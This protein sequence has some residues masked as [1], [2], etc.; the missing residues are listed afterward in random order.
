MLESPGFIESDDD[1]ILQVMLEAPWCME[2]DELLSKYKIDF[3]AHDE[4]PYVM[5]VDK[6]SVSQFSHM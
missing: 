2:S 5:G 1:C 4:A 6:G 3:I